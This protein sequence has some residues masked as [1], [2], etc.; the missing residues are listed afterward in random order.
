MMNATVA[1]RLHCSSLILAPQRSASSRGIEPSQEIKVAM[2][3]LMVASA[4]RH[5]YGK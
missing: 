5:G 4:T 1:R 3:A 2:A